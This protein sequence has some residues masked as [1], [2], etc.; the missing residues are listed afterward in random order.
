MFIYFIENPFFLS[1]IF[2]LH[3]FSSHVIGQKLSDPS[4]Q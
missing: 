4:V 1:S 2:L 3:E